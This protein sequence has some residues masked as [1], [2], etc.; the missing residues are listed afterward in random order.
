MRCGNLK[1]MYPRR[2]LPVEGGVFS[3]SVKL[4]VIEY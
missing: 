4:S 2:F 1:V 3:G